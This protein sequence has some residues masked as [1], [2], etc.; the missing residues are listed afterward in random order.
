MLCI[1]Y[2]CSTSSFSKGDFYIKDYVS[3]IGVDG[4]S[5]NSPPRSIINSC[6]VLLAVRT[7]LN[8]YSSDKVIT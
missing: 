3:T 2:R 6:N 8:R 7:L 5:W 4:V 1:N